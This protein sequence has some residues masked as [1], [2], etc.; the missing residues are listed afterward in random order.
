MANKNKYKAWLT[1]LTVWHATKKKSCY[2]LLSRLKKL[3]IEEVVL[4]RTFSSLAAVHLEGGVF[5]RLFCWFGEL[6]FA[7]E[8][9]PRNLLERESLAEIRELFLDFG[10]EFFRLPL[11]VPPPPVLLFL[12]ECEECE[13]C[14]DSPLRLRGA[15]LCLPAGAWWRMNMRCSVYG[16][17]GC[18]KSN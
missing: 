4:D 16:G 1:P 10:S 3:H 17:G 18:E 15:G 8:S 13:R 6:L 7:S 9:E 5:F 14:G 12:Q 2:W 11:S